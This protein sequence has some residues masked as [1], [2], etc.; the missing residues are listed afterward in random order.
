MG[1][2]YVLALGLHRRLHGLRRAEDALPHEGGQNTA[3]HRTE[4]EH[5]ICEK[6]NIHQIPRITEGRHRGG[7]E[8]GGESQAG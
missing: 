3:E 8:A 6:E 5:P 1:L 2:Q 7:G 4:P